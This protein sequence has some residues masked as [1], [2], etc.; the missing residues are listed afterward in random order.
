M[1]KAQTEKDLP[2]LGVLGGTFDPIHYG[3]LIIAQ[4]LVEE[5]NLA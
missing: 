4:S 2:A 3:H 5:L 1:T